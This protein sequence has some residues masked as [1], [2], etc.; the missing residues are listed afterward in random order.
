MIIGT[1]HISLD[2]TKIKLYNYV[3]LLALHD[4]DGI[5]L[6]VENSE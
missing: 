3:P 1:G 2:L 6:A 5:I 4:Y